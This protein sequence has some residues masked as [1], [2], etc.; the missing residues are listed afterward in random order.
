MSI[1]LIQ[2]DTNKLKLDDGADGSASAPL[3][4][5]A[6]FGRGSGDKDITYLALRNASGTQVF[7]YP[8]A[9]GTGV[10]VSTTAP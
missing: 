3:V 10:T 5:I 4:E 1:N 8:N 9:G 6:E 2:T 7:I